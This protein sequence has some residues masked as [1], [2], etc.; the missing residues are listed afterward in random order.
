MPKSGPS[1]CLESALLLWAIAQHE[2]STNWSQ[3]WDAV[4]KI[5]VLGSLQQSLHFC[6]QGHIGALA[7]H[8][9]KHRPGMFRM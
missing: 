8:R 6:K 7:Q 4:A 1:K 3:F 9:G 5:R 2:S